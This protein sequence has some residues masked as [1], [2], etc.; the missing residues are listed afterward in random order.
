[1]VG[2]LVSWFFVFFV[3][4][5]GLKGMVVKVDFYMKK[6]YLGFCYGFDK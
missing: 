2:I 6:I 5:F 3:V 4:V 1:M